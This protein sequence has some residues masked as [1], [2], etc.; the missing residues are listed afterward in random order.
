MPQ[1]ATIAAPLT[2]L[3]CKDQKNPVTWSEECG[4]AFKTLKAFLCSPVIK[5]PNFSQRIVLQVDSSAAGL[6]AVLAE[7]HPGEECPVV[8]LSRKLWPR[9]SRYPT[10]EKESLAI[11]WALESLRYYLRG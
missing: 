7:G 4:H 6:G 10:V 3:I 1:F 11:K 2:A 5:S 8:F 9:E